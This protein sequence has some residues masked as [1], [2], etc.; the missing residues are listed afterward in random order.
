M[1]IM[2]FAIE[3]CNKNAATR[4]IAMT[5]GRTADL[6]PL[7]EGPPRQMK[8]TVPGVLATDEVTKSCCYPDGVKRHDPPCKA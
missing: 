5:M 7:L 2:K 3:H 8:K 1:A 4:A 6:A